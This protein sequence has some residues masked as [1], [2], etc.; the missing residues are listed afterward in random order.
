MRP[1]RKPKHRLLTIGLVILG[2]LALTFALAGCDNESAEP[3]QPGDMAP[4]GEAEPW[5][6]GPGEEPM[7]IDPDLAE[8][9][10]PG[11][12]EDPGEMM[13]P[14]DQLQQIPP[15]DEATIKSLTAAASAFSAS[16][17]NVM[18]YDNFGAWAAARVGVSGQ[19]GQLAIFYYSGSWTLADMGSYVEPGDLPPSIPGEVRNWAFP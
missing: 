9:M 6:P 1:D 13:V 5:E 12:G 14:P 8:T 7:E 2:V 10:E 16:Q 4:P 19:E 18:D 17:I 15:I 11:P 3:N